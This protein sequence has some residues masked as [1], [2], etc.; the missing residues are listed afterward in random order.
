MKQY[1]VS[2]GPCISSAINCSNPANVIDQ[3]SFC[4]G[5]RGDG[6]HLLLDGAIEVEELPA[7][8]VAG[9]GWGVRSWTEIPSGVGEGTK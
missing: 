2:A 1:V 6:T 8:E 3:A 5:C 7:D 4:R 9:L